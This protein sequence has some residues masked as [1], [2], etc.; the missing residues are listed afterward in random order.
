MLFVKEIDYKTA[1]AFIKEHH[2]SR[3]MPRGTNVCF[4]W[5]A[6][7]HLYAVANYGVGIS[8]TAHAYLAENTTLPV[9]QF[10]LFE[11]KRLCRVG[12]KEDP[13]RNP[14]TQFLSVCHKILR[15]KHGIAFIVSF[16]D[17]EHG[18][19]GEVYRIA[20]FI[21]L[22][23][24][25]AEVH[26]VGLDGAFVHRR[27]PY[28]QMRRYNVK[29]AYELYPTEMEEACESERVALNLAAGSTKYEVVTMEMQHGN[30]KRLLGNDAKTFRQAV[31]DGG[32]IKRITMPKTR[33]FLP[34]VPEHR[35]KLE[36]LLR[37]R[38]QTITKEGE[39]NLGALM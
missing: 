8:M 38:R 13:S 16:S 35:N 6:G 23:S 19:E 30:A 25:K 22:G 26:Y 37:D 5:F 17:P 27:V 31:A 39:M 11:L 21:K 18:H 20:N 7:E 10:N 33:W 14:L 34:L 36:T 24:T 9:T 28:Q 2:Y 12:G 1:K 4:G 29:F 32:F 3:K 15:K